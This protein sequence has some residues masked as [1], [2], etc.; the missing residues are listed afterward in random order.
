MKFNYDKDTDSLYINLIDI[1]GVDS[2]EIAPDFIADIDSMGRVVG[3]EVLNVG[4]KVD[5]HSFIF[6]KIP[7]KDVQFI[8][9][10]VVS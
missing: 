10:P 2:F 8:N 5:L 7:V 1:A 4:E 9:Q 6:D 3:I